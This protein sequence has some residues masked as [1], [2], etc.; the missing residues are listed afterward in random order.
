MS[1]GTVT[2]A[3]GT[4]IA[5]SAWGEGDPIVIIDGATAHRATTPENAAV[6]ELLA[7]GFRVVNHDRRGRG[8]SGDTAPYTVEREFE[9]LA[10]VIDRE[11]GGRPVT[12][13]GWSSGGH[14][15]LNAALCVVIV[16][17][18]RRGGWSP[19]HSAAVATAC[20]AVRGLLAFTYFPLIGEV[21]PGPKY[22][23][24]AVMLAVVV[25]AAEF[26]WRGSGRIRAS[27]A[28]AEEGEPVAPSD[29]P[30]RR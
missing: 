6:A 3:D 24:N 11:G 5:Y 4:V 10:A 19:W 14:L 30:V 23:H 26:A 9:D 29:A 22:A 21:E 13:F 16:R 20:L 15:A 25:L 17:A 12:V 27:A 8:A 7:D 18:V 1:E 28:A 2:S